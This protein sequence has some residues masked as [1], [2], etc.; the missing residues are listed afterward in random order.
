MFHIQKPKT[1]YELEMVC[2]ENLVP[3][4]H[5]L[6]LI[7]THI[8]FS[9]IYEKVR[10]YYSETRGRRSLDPVMLFKMIFIGYLYNIRSERQLEKEIMV[11]TAYRWFL[12]L[13]L[14]E[15]VPDHSSISFNRNERFKGTTVFQDIFDE[16]VRIA[17][18][19]GLVGGRVLITDSTHMRANAN[20]NQYQMQEIAYTTEEYMQELE[21]AV[22]QEREANGKKP[23]PPSPEADS[24]TMKV[25]TTD[26]QSGHM[27]RKGKP[28]GFHYLDH[29]TVDHKSN[30]IT[31]VH[32]TAGNV[33][34]STVYMERLHYQVE[35]FGFASTL[36]A[37]LLDSGYM[38][39]YICH[40]TSEM[41]I[42]AIIAER[43]A[44]TYPDIFPKEQFPFVAERNV[45]VCP[46][47][48]E[49]VYTTTN[50]SG[51]REYRSS[52]STCESC[53]LLAKCTTNQ[54][55]QRTIQRHIW[56]DSKEKVQQN[57]QSDDGKAVYR[58][59]SQTI[60]RSFAD[61]KELHG[62]RR[63]RFRGRD[64]VQFQALMTAAVQNLKKIALHLARRAG[65]VA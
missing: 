50:R 21:N 34:D 30:I 58:L 61:A 49:L 23:L 65:K 44:P 8:D 14:S 42:S 2:L 55:K 54:S 63:C 10:P 64:N 19:H 13:G 9:F 12:G 40:K 52:R 39:P 41:N 20:N 45:Y 26:P 33:N 27:M 31:D 35:K 43:A 5:F 37:V 3:Q 56:E 32:V 47:G 36:E 62:L 4:D 28:E 53:P 48:Q 25:S 7:E 57:R 17:C 60:E 1:Q 15:K 29:R 6:R 46:A 22:N 16:I 24:K 51:Y 18:R 11:N 59:R 38:T